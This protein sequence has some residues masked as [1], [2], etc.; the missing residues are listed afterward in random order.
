MG[1]NYYFI[2]VFCSGIVLIPQLYG[3]DQKILWDLF[4]NEY[5]VPTSCGCKIHTNHPPSASMFSSLS[6][7]SCWQSVLTHMYSLDQ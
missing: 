6:W 7:M 2:K 3:Q 4:V 5:K 1:I